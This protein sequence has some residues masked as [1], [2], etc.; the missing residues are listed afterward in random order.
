MNN[1]AEE[2]KRKIEFK[3]IDDDDLPPIMITIGEGDLPKVVLNQKHKIW[4]SLN[5]KC[6]GG[7]AESLY[8]KID[9]LLTAHLSEQRMYEK[10]E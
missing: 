8:E 2:K 3:L 7:C 10:M 5:R 6:I 4:L 1:I 9:E